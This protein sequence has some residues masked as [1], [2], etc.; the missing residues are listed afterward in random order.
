MFAPAEMS[1]VDIFVF[2]NDIEDVAQ[3]IARLGVLHLLDVNTL[4]KWAQDVSTEWVG[5]V[6]TYTTQERRVLELLNELGIEQT[7]RACEGRLDPAE[8]L[9]G[10]EEELRQVE[11]QTHSM[12]ERQE[13]LQ[14]QLERWVLLEQSLDTLA[15][16]SISISDLRQFQYLHL[17]AGTLPA[18]N[19]ARLEASL[20]RIPYR[21]IPV[22]NYRGR[23][24]V[25]AF[26][27]QEHAA[28]L[29]RALESAFLD[30]MTLP[31]EF[32]GTA[33][34]VLEQIQEKRRQAEEE[35]TRLREEKQILAEDLAPQ[36]LS[37]W[38]RI[39]RDR[40]ISDAMAHF[41]HRGR[42]YLIAG[43]APRD[44][45]QELRQAV[46]KATDGRVTFEENS[47]YAPGERVQVPTLMRH[48]RLLRPVESLVSTYGTP[49]YNELDPT[50][51]VALTFIIMF[52]I[53]FGDL[54]HGIVLMLAGAV[55]AL[56]LI[57]QAA[58]LADFGIILFFAG[59]S[60]S[61]F[62]ILYGSLFGM[63]GIIPQ[64]WLNPLD[65]ILTLLIASVIFGVI[66]LNIG[67]AFR[68]ATAA[69]QGAYKE[70]IFDR[71]GVV[72]LLLYWSLIGMVVSVATGNG[73]PLWLVG[74]TLLLMLALFLAEPL[75]RL[76]EG[77][78]PLV[79]GSL[80]ELAVQY[81]FELFEAIIS[82]LSNTLSYVR[83]GAFAV[84]HVGLSLVVFLLA[85]LVGQG[86]PILRFLVIAGGNLFIIGFEG[87]IVAIQTLRLEYYELFGKFY[88]GEGIPFQ[89][90]TLPAMECDIPES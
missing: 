73:L 19:L 81:F 51:L 17:V 59:L 6:S 34:E 58:N 42:V 11:E 45:V 22:H 37:L 52:G 29:D 50:P 8:D 54:G 9:V 38:T 82:Y 20:F 85:D 28:I 65:D 47:P 70:A 13:A 18:E 10:I 35:L 14:Q 49:G 16:L 61:I 79:E 40:A 30:P 67:F 39:R 36:L 7:P 33:Q 44:R 25:F 88:R 57:P 27:A 77:K 15:P 56:R 68:L 76:I 75:T 3:I 71:N 86:N 87:L 12:I 62:G 60:S 69:R 41:G 23:V 43:W 89:P 21:I 66:L 31:E 74:I 53:M 24:L 72:G 46:E 48:S 90:L 63:E 32:E 26:S 5:R 78:R 2:E 84:A 1:E 4:G 64:L 83:L 55:L 80:P